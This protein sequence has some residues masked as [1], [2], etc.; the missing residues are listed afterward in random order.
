V[1]ES[2]ENLQVLDTL[3]DITNLISTTSY[4]TSNMC[5]LQVWKIQCLLM[6]NVKDE[7]VLIKNMAKLMIVKFDKY[8]DEYSV[9]FCIWCNFRLENEV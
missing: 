8:W 5:F 2:W 1:G 7:D 4:P 3:Y 9:V 6:E